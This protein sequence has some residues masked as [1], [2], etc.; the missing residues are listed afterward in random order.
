MRLI[1]VSFISIMLAFLLCFGTSCYY[2]YFYPVKYEEIVY[3]NSRK[4]EISPEIIASIINV[5]S[6]YKE[7]SLSN[8]GAV[9][10]MQILPSTAQWISSKI[11]LNYE[12]LYSPE[13]NIEFGTFYLSYLLECFEDID[14]AICAYNAGQG[15]VNRWLSTK[16]YSADGK[17]LNK[18]PFK[19]TREYLSKVKKNMKIYKNKFN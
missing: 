6:G 19:E 2:A 9:G 16:E 12:S 4:Y 10:L 1:L 8:K 7:N 14:L 18:I 13:V 5:E 15:N 11:G 17:S 3:A